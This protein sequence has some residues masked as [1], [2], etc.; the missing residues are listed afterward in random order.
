[1][2][3]KKSSGKSTVT[4]TR[5][6]AVT[7]TRQSTRETT[8]PERFVPPSRIVPRL[9]PRGRRVVRSVSAPIPPDRTASP[10]AMS[11]HA[12]TEAS[13]M[14]T[15]PSAITPST[16]EAGTPVDIDFGF[17][18]ETSANE[19][20]HSAPETPHHAAQEVSPLD[21]LFLGYVDSTQFAAH[22][23]DDFHGSIGQYSPDSIDNANDSIAQYSVGAPAGTA[24]VLTYLDD[25]LDEFSMEGQVR[26]LL[27]DGFPEAP[28][29]VSTPA[30]A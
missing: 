25:V 10:V 26:T 21:G 28:A 22:L 11:E 6:P 23:D 2:A 14:S 20:T 19:L 12:V 4:P 18:I 24:N 15:T 5:T 3:P 9:R 13:S 17:S 16:T 27:A 8:P 29:D 30:F 1:M 7:P